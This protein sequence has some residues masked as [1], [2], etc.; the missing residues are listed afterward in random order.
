MVVEE[1]LDDGFKGGERFALG[2]V[3]V[4]GIWVSEA[5]FEEFFLVEFLEVY[6]DGDVVEVYN[7]QE[8]DDVEQDILDVVG[9]VFVEYGEEGVFAWGE[10]DGVGDWE[11][12]EKDWGGGHGSSSREIVNL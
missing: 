5:S 9:V 6:G 1:V 12:L 7:V 3:V 4:F 11:V 8:V 10:G 2:V